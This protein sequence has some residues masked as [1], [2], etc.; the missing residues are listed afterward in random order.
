M[1][2]HFVCKVAATEFFYTQQGHAEKIDNVNDSNVFKETLDAFKMLDISG[3][4]QSAIF[5]LVSAI[6]HLGNVQI[7]GERANESSCVPV[8]SLEA[9]LDLKPFDY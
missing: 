6:M 9:Y 2:R 1:T 3:V 8:R 4:D 7:V 5:S